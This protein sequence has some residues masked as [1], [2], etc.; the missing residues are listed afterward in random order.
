MKRILFI[1]SLIICFNASATHIVGGEIMYK[2]S[3]KSNGMLIYDI[4]MYLYID[5]IN[6][7]QGAIDTDVNGYINAFSYDP[8]TKIYAMYKSQQLTNARTGPN[9]V[10]DV[11]YKCIK[12]KPNACVDKYVFAIT[13]ALPA[14]DGGYV[15]AFE[16]CCRNNSINNIINP[17]STGATYWTLIPSAKKIPVNSSPF[18]KSLPPNFLCTNAPLN[19]DHSA[20]DADGDSL[21]YELY[22]PYIGATSSSPLPTPSEATY[23]DRFLPIDWIPG[24]YDVSNQIDGQ[25]TLSINRRTGKLTLTPTNTGQFVIGIK[26]MEFRKGKFIGET[27]RDFQFNV[28]NC[29]FDVVSSFGIPYYN[30]SGDLL[31][32]LNRSQGATNF[33]WDFGVDTSLRDTSNLKNPSY[34]YNAQG[35]YTVSLIASST[36]SICTD[37]SQFDIYVKEKFNTK[38]NNDTLFCGPFTKTLATNTPGKSYLWST[39]EKTATITVNKGGKYSVAVSDLPCVARDTITIINDLSVLDLGP[40]SVICRDSFIQFTYIGKPGYKSYLW[41]DGSTN[42]SVFIPKLATYWVNVLNKNNCPS[43]DS[44][45]FVLYPP[46]RVNL[47]DT[48]F[49]KGTSVLLDGVNYSF[50]TKLETNYLWN[51]GDITPQ[52]VRST[53]GTYIVKV[54]NKLCTIIDTATIDFI[55][56]G[57]ELGN[58]TFYCGPVFRWLRPL[59]TYS[60]YLWQDNSEGMDYLARTAGKKKLTITTKEGCIESDSIFL[61]QY[62]NIDGG[63]G[64]DTTI[65]LSSRL[66]LKARDSMVS[67]LWNTGATS[68]SIIIKDGGTYTVTVKNINNCIVSDT[69]HI[70]ED[71]NIIPSEMYMPN[72]FSPNEDMLNDFYPGNNYRD[73]GA[74]YLLMI[75]NRWGEK[76]FESKLPSVQWNGTYKDEIAPQD[77]YVFYVKYVACDEKEHWVRGTFTLLR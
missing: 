53:P 2:Y 55:Y 57:L 42:Q 51:T 18:F 37:T 21:V 54:R 31:S 60:K 48:L 13:M 34:K 52:I 33:H 50:K 77:V 73:P 25:P 71:P 23:P 75:Y 10:S 22:T 36:V 6:G 61:S 24:S 27:K 66:E 67:Y 63:L 5:C 49:C 70:K 35:F 44:I 59:H 17:Q 69:I 32:F 26:V 58:D 28:S 39:G 9:K 56:T 12:T 74:D 3:G 16:R 72:A 1:I 40:D 29:T 30:C 19:F 41:N 68:S 7:Q 38:L 4:T 43:R 65:C 47:H 76:I 11:N 15:L 8:A 62:P 46:P 64:N 20:T 14:N 45:T